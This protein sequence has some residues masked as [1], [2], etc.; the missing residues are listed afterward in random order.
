MECRWH[1]GG[2]VVGYAEARSCSP[3]TQALIESTSY[4]VDLRVFVEVSLRLEV[5]Q[6]RLGKLCCD[7]E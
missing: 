6:V 2:S 7:R 5:L 3:E 4:V 1:D